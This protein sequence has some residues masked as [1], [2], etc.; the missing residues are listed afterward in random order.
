MHAAVFGSMARGE[1]RPGS[2]IDLM[3]DLDPAKALGVYDFADIKITLGEMLGR[4][5]D[6]VERRA[7][8]EL[9]RREALRESVD[10]F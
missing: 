7:L 3:V 4:N 9:V 6:L 10:V 8:K 5:V 1:A 2:D